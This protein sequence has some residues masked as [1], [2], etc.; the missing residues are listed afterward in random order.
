[1][2]KE[3]YILLV[4]MFLLI[5]TM[6]TYSQE[7]VTTQNTL[8]NEQVQKLI[9]ETEQK[10]N[11]VLK[12]EI[13]LP[14]LAV[15]VV[16]KDKVMW[17]KA[18]GYRDD[19]RSQ[20]TDTNTI[21]S[22]QSISKT[23]TIAGLMIAVQEGL[24]NLDVPIKTY[25]PDFHIQTR[26]SDD[27]MTSITIRHLLSM[28]SGLTHDAPVGNNADPFT[29]SNKD[30]I[31]SISKTWLRF[32]T[33][34]RY[35]YSNLGIELAAYILETIIHKPFTEYIREKVLEPLGMNRSTYDAERIRKDENRAIGTN[36]N[37]EQVPLNNPYFAA[38]GV[39]A[40]INDMARFLLFQLNDGK[41]NGNQLINEQMI[42]Q[43]RTIPFPM[44]DQV[45]GYGLGMFI[46]YYHL[47][48]KDV[49]W[50]AHGGGGFGFQCQMKWLPDLGYG[51]IVLTNSSDQDYGQERIVED[52]LLQIVEQLTG[53]KN[54]GPSDWLNRHPTSQLVDSTY[55][56][57]NL[58]GRYN[59]TNDDWFFL[60]K[61]DKFGYANGNSFEPL[62]AISQTE[63]KS[64]RYLYRFICDADG[65]PISFIRTYDGMVWLLGKSDTELK[66]PNKKEWLK[67]TG[68]YVRKRFGVGEKFYNV[69]VKNGWLHFE[70]MGQDFRLT[71]YLPGL[72]FTPDG[73]AIDFRNP[74]PTFRNIN[75]YKECN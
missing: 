25:L 2:R 15:A 39:Y 35:E 64:K 29:P 28:T 36:K 38:G 58:V 14:G 72:F 62:I 56:P 23:I 40:S 49:R 51:V 59:G 52:I 31:Q 61:E 37:F 12:K 41:I 65:T 53:K 50:L 4:S 66:G 46:G 71:E 16:S 60:I 45:A 9:Q 74:V 26:F 11:S 7:I 42:K 54:L 24:I 8:S 18:F 20:R 1:M 3:N 70:G 47:G 5:Y 73:E 30:H 63:F 17:I 75:L 33:G 67:Y 57:I 6:Q 48:G 55:L 21:Y 19:L 22:L 44:K 13:F 69:S 43:M 68:S 34:E 27:P 32:R 10:I